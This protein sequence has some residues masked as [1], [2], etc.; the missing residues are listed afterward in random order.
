MPVLQI[1]QRFHLGLRT[2]YVGIRTN[3]LSFL[4]ESISSKKLRLVS[5]NKI[6]ECSGWWG[7]YLIS[8]DSESSGELF[9]P[10]QTSANQSLSWLASRNRNKISLLANGLCFKLCQWHGCKKR[11]FPFI[12]TIVGLLPALWSANLR[13]VLKREVDSKVIKLLLNSSETCIGGV[14][15]NCVI[16]R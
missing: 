4:L 5:C 16:L 1:L 3:N 14:L 15:G 13:L 11:G 7:R 8:G 9:Q 10:P 12:P 6:S 2:Q